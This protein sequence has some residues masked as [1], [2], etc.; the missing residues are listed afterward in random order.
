MHPDLHKSSLDHG[1]VGLLLRHSIGNVHDQNSMR[2]SN[3]CIL[4]LFLLLIAWF[5]IIYYNALK[6]T[7]VIISIWKNMNISYVLIKDFAYMLTIMLAK[8]DHTTTK[9]SFSCEFEVLWEHSQALGKIVLA[10]CLP[11]YIHHVVCPTVDR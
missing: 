2:H 4:L 5:M 11:C 6:K 8:N 7:S 10:L 3:V 9:P 1:L